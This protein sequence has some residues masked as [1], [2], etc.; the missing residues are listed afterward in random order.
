MGKS[1]N[2]CLNIRLFNLQNCLLKEKNW[3][4]VYFEVKNEKNGLIDWY[5]EIFLKEEYTLVEVFDNQES[6]SPMVHMSSVMTSIALVVI[7]DLQVHQPYVK[8]NLLNGELK[9]ET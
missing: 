9:E 7:Q 6:F 4:Q 5:K 1:L 8:T 2:H 3:L